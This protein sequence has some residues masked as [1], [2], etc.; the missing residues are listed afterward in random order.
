MSNIVNSKEIII[1]DIE[2][3]FSKAQLE[4]LIGIPK[5]TLASV[6][7]GKRSFSKKTA[8]KIS[9]WENS[10]KPNPFGLVNEDLGS[11]ITEK[12]VKKEKV[13][14]PQVESNV[15]ER[16]VGESGI[17]YLIRCEE[18]KNKI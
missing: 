3:G 11:V 10:D 14:V 13:V 17:D 16:L 5:N 4:K 7:S 2:N 18:L 15:P 1:K 8:A 6:L 12:I 9:I